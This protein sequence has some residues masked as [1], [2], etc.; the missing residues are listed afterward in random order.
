M[1]GKSLILCEGGDDIGFLKKLCKYLKLDMKG[2]IIRKISQDSDSNG[3]SAF[4]KEDSYKT[5]KQYI[6]TGYYSKVLFVVDA[7]YIENDSLYGG[8]ENTKR[9]LNK[10]IS[11]LQFEQ[12]AKY[13]IM[14]DPTNKTG[15]LEHLILSTIKDE[16]K[17]CIDEFLKCILEMDVHSN[18]KIILSS[19]EAIFRESPYNFT[20]SNFRE[21]K[22]LL[23]NLGNSI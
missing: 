19:Y 21:L 6:D 5:I 13:F 12:K 11:T 22:T 1:V 4:F 20:H 2:I 17:E 23:Q 10:I 9:E 14:C 16:K 7:D 3:K 8:F 15:N 18:K